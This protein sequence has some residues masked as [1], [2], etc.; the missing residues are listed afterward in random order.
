M[1]NLERFFLPELLSSNN[2]LLGVRPAPRVPAPEA[3]RNMV[4]IESGYVWLLWI[5]GVPFLL[6]YF[7]FTVV[8]LRR[9]RRVALARPDAVGCAAATGFCATIA[10][11]VLMLFDP[12]LTTRGAADIFFPMLALALVPC[13]VPMSARAP[14]NIMPH[15]SVPLWG[16]KK[17]VYEP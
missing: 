13:C 9:L 14:T 16:E 1:A 17:L 11:T 7:W 3:W 2:W 10:M 15:R 5:G 4:Y 12:H 6:A 8:T